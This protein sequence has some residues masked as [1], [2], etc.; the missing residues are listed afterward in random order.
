M[1]H[2][3]YI[4]Q[5]KGGVGKSLIAALMMQY[6]EDNGMPAI[7]V[8]TDPV[9]A[10]FTAYS[11]FPTIRLELLDKHQSLQPRRFDDLMDLILAN[12][13]KDI[14]IDNGASSF[15]PLASYL[16]ENDVMPM[17]QDMGRSVVVHTVITGGQ[18]M[19]DTLNG[20]LSLGKNMDVPLALWVNGYFGEIV[21]GGKSFEQ[22]SVYKTVRDKIC[23]IVQI[24]KMSP[25][26]EDDFRTML[27]RHL[28]FRQ[29]LEDPD[30]NL[31]A[32]NRLRKIQKNIY[33]QLDQLQAAFAM[34]GAK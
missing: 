14:I 29:A 5:G 21:S 15:I 11:A 16:V 9:N 26:F 1:P 28:V 12:E 30:F 13:D 4:L 3:H 27:E 33:S 25:L 34:I 20:L 32:K 8:D 22:M 23:G 7:A 31:M 24:E 6:Q 18:A 17:L 10:S 19:M 2:I